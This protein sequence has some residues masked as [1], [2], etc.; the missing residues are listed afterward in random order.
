V[1]P[2]E[3]LIEISPETYPGL[4]IGYY[5]PAIFQNADHDHTQDGDEAYVAVG[6]SWVIY[7]SG[8]VPTDLTNIGLVEGW[9]AVTFDPSSGEL[10]SVDDVN[11]IPIAVNLAATEAAALGGTYTGST[12]VALRLGLVPQIDFDGGTV[13][14]FL[15]D[16]VLSDPWEIDVS[17]APP[18]SH[19]QSLG[20]GGLMGAAEIPITYVDT[21]G[22]GGLSNGD[23]GAYA[24]CAGPYPA[25]LMYLS[26]PTN[27]SDAYLILSAG[28]HPG[29]FAV[30]G[31]GS[32]DGFR[33]MSDDEA[34]SLEI[35][36]GCSLG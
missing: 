33:V 24:A 27:L 12:D 11:A 17:G 9:N 5:I 22:S 31:D 13:G 3:D 35:G 19:F 10:Q 29:W 1:A 25:G 34:T 15:Y 28:L 26:P 20:T 7:L 8:D 30:A 36:D 2:S 18:E 6:R 23:T 16:D 32:S 4:Y 21:D 14:D